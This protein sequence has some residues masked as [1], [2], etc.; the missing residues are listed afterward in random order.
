MANDR[1]NTGQPGLGPVPRYNTP[2][3]LVLNNVTY[4]VETKIIALMKTMS[5][6]FS[7]QQNA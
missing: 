7:K 6:P 3:H 4:I 5:V 2:T 1:G